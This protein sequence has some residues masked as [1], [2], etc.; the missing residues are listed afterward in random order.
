MPNNNSLSPTPD[1][2]EPEEIDQRIKYELEIKRRIKKIRKKR[3]LSKP[4]PQSES[5]K[6]EVSLPSNKPPASPE[7]PV[8]QQSAT[9]KENQKDQQETDRSSPPQQQSSQESTPRDLTQ[10][11]QR[12]EKAQKAVAKT[13]KAQ[14]T[15]KGAGAATK[16]AG[17]LATGAL[18]KIGLSALMASLPAWLPL[19]AAVVLGIIV[20]I[21]TV[22]LILA[23]FK[24]AGHSTPQYPN[25]A[26]TEDKAAVG[27]VLAASSAQDL[28]L[29][30]SAIGTKTK[31]TASV[32]A[33]RIKC[34]PSNQDC[35]KAKQKAQ[36]LATNLKALAISGP[37]Q[38]DY[39]KAKLDESKKALETLSQSNV[40]PQ[41]T[42]N[43]VQELKTQWESY[44]KN[45]YSLFKLG[46]PILYFNS[47]DLAMIKQGKVD[48]RIIAVLNKLIDFSLSQN[49]PRWSMFK[50]GRIFKATPYA[51]REAPLEESKEY[52]SAHHFG[53]ALDI[54]VVGKYKCTIR[55]LTGKKTIWLPCYVSFQGGAPSYPPV[56]KASN[57]AE[58]TAPY[59]LSGLQ[60]ELGPVN[61]EKTRSFWESFMELG[62]NVIREQLGIPQE[63]WYT[64]TPSIP[65]KILIAYLS[66]KTNLPPQAIAEAIQHGDDKEALVKGLIAFQ[67]NLPLGSLEGRNWEERFVNA[68]KAYIRRALGLEG[69]TLQDL[70][71]SLDLGQAILQKQFGVSEW[72]EEKK[73]QIFDT[74][75]LSETYYQNLWHLSKAEIEALIEARNF[76]A[77]AKKVG[78]NFY[79]DFIT[80]G[81]GAYLQ[82]WLGLPAGDL[83][84]HDYQVA[85]GRYIL[86]RALRLPE[87]L[88]AFQDSDYFFREGPLA[89]TAN[90]DLCASTTEKQNCPLYLFFINPKQFMEK[91]Q[92][93][94]EK[95][96]TERLIFRGEF[97]E[98]LKEGLK[99]AQIDIFSLPKV[100]KDKNRRKQL[101]TSLS[102]Y[103]AQRLGDDFTLQT[104]LPGIFEQIKQE[105][106]GFVLKLL[107]INHFAT[108]AGFP[109]NVLEKLT[110]PDISTEEVIEELAAYKALEAMGIN[111]WEVDH[112]VL[113][114]DWFK[115][116]QKFASVATV[117]WLKTYGLDFASIDND[118]KL[119]IEINSFDDAIDL[120][121]GDAPEG[122]YP[123][124]LA[125]FLGIS[126]E[127]LATI[128][129]EIRSGRLSQ[130][131][132]VIL[133]EI[134]QRL[135][136]PVDLT[137]EMLQGKTTFS[138]WTEKI[139]ENQVLE[140]WPQ[141]KAQDIFG[142][143]EQ[144]HL[145]IKELVEGIR[146][147]DKDA[148]KHFL[149]SL[150]YS[151]L[152][153]IFNIP[154]EEI[155]RFFDPTTLRFETKE[156]RR[157]GIQYLA[158]KIASDATTYQAL[159]DL[160]NTYFEKSPKDILKSKQKTKRELN[161]TIAAS[162]EVPAREAQPFTDNQLEI[163]FV[164]YSAAQ[165]AKLNKAY[166]KEKGMSYAEIKKIF[167]GDPTQQK[168]SSNS[169]SEIARYH[170]TQKEI[171][172]QELRKLTYSLVDINLIK[173]DNSIP[174]GFTQALVEGS[175]EE[176]AKTLALWLTNKGKL[177]ISFVSL[178]EKVVI[179]EDITKIKWED[180][181]NY[182]PGLRDKLPNPQQLKKTWEELRSLASTLKEAQSLKEA[183]KTFAAA[184]ELISRKTNISLGK[185]G[186]FVR[187]IDEIDTLDFKQIGKELEPTQTFLGLLQN[188]TELPGVKIAGI[189]VD[190][191]DVLLAIAGANPVNILIGKIAGK[192]LGKVL[193][194]FGFGKIK[195]ENRQLVARKQV[196]TTIGQ[197]LETKP[198][199]PLQIITLRKE[200]LYYFSGLNEEGQASEKLK[201]IL[202]EKYGPLKERGNK[203]LF[204]SPLMWDHIHVGY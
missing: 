174:P 37:S 89:P 154:P 17:R 187:L 102:Q 159:V 114:S 64:G 33:S 59:A 93:I 82:R 36:K 132:S 14:K 193:K 60:F 34:P 128:V 11:I 201:D 204:T 41:E 70:T 173:K 115:D 182:I 101:L 143:P 150:G 73:Q 49:S 55:K 4:F 155:Q 117:L 47:F 20:V 86:A 190:L 148:T 162:L 58:L 124:Q 131:T 185:V 149:V 65:E 66:Q 27:R 142:L 71:S 106:W 67:L 43:Q 137:I 112:S 54:T 172:K 68:Y 145:N 52:L 98:V 21:I 165:L 8:S 104:E 199:P 186:E 156:L 80:K 147:N 116:P 144:F 42:K 166:L 48:K 119:K 157:L 109:P 2:E 152:G 29:L 171:K 19:I 160:F 203:G 69:T 133:R 105:N 57:Y 44:L 96:L 90:L 35:L 30:A 138:G 126:T 200:D 38:K 139:W 129:K 9:P 188:F 56:G 62:E 189:S 100:W 194:I 130:T 168:P 23:I 140:S 39:I 151:Q 51:K 15:L 16:I 196:R 22:V 24:G 77:L 94:V 97:G 88:R 146:S 76:D 45:N 181:Y 135:G 87:P 28:S 91:T 158:A 74:I 95:S 99:S 6:S 179:D 118:G 127:E 136:L 178:F 169:V 10:K 167:V 176:K 63:H 175:K 103:I 121:V 5:Q 123:A 202:T 81:A 84:D 7:Q 12:A 79:R 26:S 184:E 107:G 180:L 61:L 85:A 78:K 161:Y 3:R 191:G 13:Q 25:L 1:N 40:L 195:C 111:H 198:Y 134:N 53:Q 110:L 141:N 83:R 164:N 125:S 46:S 192:V 170:E 18:K 120:L 197:I 177:P 122:T 75:A 153:K 92:K 113:P 183:F 163:G 32:I 108:E 72:T 31:D 50:I